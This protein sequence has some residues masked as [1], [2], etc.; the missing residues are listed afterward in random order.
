MSV[1]LLAFRLPAELAG[2]WAGRDIGALVPL[3]I[4]LQL[5]AAAVWLL[6]HQSARTTASRES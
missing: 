5:A 4:V 6:R 3:L 2:L 1:F